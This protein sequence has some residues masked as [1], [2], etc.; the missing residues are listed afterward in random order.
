[1]HLGRE[2]KG[3]SVH[4][5]YY[6][7][8]PFDGSCSYQMSNITPGLIARVRTGKVVFYRLQSKTAESGTR[9]AVA[10]FVSPDDPS[11]MLDLLAEALSLGY[12][13]DEIYKSPKSLY[14]QRNV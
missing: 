12:A 8:G 14:T 9:K 13:A 11:D 1:M 7:G 3:I 2:Q 10:Q 4:T 5:I 6:L